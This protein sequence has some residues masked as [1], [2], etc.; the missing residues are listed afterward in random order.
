MRT[1]E[2]AAHLTNSDVAVQVFDNERNSARKNNGFF[3]LTVQK[4]L[5]NRFF[6]VHSGGHRGCRLYLGEQR[7]RMFSASGR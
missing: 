2:N 1:F 3:S 7:N 6:L 5:T 4:K